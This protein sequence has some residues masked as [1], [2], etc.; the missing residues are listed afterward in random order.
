MVY[1]LTLL[2]KI[3][4][5]KMIMID[6]SSIIHRMIFSSVKQINP[7]KIDGLY[8]TKEYVNLT[9][10]LILD[11]LFNIHRT[12]S[13]VFGE[14]CIC[15]DRSENGY[16]RRDFYPGYKARRKVGRDKSEINYGEVFAEIEGLIDQLRKNVPWKVLEVD[17]A[18]ADDILLVLAK[19]LNHN[20]KILIHSPDKDMIQAQ[21]ETSNV[22]QYSALTN[23]WLTPESKYENMEQWIQEHV[24]LGDTSDDVPKVV[25]STVFSPIFLDYLKEHDLT[26]KDPVEFKNSE[27]T[28]EEKFKLLDEFNV[29]KFNRKGEDTGVLDIYKNPAFGPAGLAKAIKLHGSLDAWLDSHPMYRPNYDRNFVLVMSEGI[30][31]FYWNAIIQQYADAKIDYNK[32]ELECYLS[33]NGLKSLILEL[34][35]HFKFTGEL[36]AAD[37]GW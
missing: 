4:D 19:E 29:N 5:T 18:E 34:P 10:Y 22:F 2:S 33:E 32:S 20:E 37:F 27:M 28:K 35:N 15:L 7:Q 24:V 25:D 31:E 13:S 26:I 6:F 9:K 1:W 30:P 3:G 36:S 8:V 14:M 21:R 17:K 11:E 16:W 12:H 23:K